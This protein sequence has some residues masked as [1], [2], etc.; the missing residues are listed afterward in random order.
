M[1]AWQGEHRGA[2][3][4]GGVQMG[5]LEWLSGTGDGKDVGIR[6]PAKADEKGLNGEGEQ[7]RRTPGF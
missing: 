6:D 1:Q 5:V 3:L 2:G 4:A 7:E